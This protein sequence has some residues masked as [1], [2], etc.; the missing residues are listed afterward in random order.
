MLVV[1]P[2]N[3]YIKVLAELRALFAQTAAHKFL[4]AFGHF[5]PSAPLA[6]VK[7]W[8]RHADLHNLIVVQRVVGSVKIATGACVTYLCEK[9]DLA[10]SAFCRSDLIVSFELTAAD[11]IDKRVVFERV[12]E[13]RLKTQAPAPGTS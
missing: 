6:P 4:I 5:N 10:L 13:C 2:L 3:Q 12:G 1:E 9:T 7:N 11:I 8:Y